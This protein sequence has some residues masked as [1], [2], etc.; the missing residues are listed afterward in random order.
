VKFRVEH[1]GQI[2]SAELDIRPLTLLVGRNNTNKTWA[3][4][5]LYG[6]L[7]QAAWGQDL[8]KL[9]PAE[10]G[11]AQRPEHDA[12]ARVVAP[13]VEQFAA[14]AFSAASPGT[15]TGQPS[16]TVS[17]SEL[18][19]PGVQSFTFHLVDKELAALLALP[20][21]L[22]AR[23][24]ASLRLDVDEAP[25]PGMKII[26]LSSDGVLE[27]GHVRGGKDASRSVEHG[28]RFFF[29]SRPELQRVLE[30][31]LGDLAL[32]SF[33]RVFA[34][35]A[36][37]KALTAIYNHLRD[38]IEQTLPKPAADFVAFLRRA[39]A[40][41]AG[42]PQTPQVNQ[43]QHLLRGIIE[44]SVSYAQ[45][46][47]GWQAVYAP[48]QETFTL[49]IQAASSLVRA[50]AGLDLM[51]DDLGRGDVLLVDEV[52]MNAHPATQ[53]ALVELLC[54]LV[55][56]GVYVIMTSHSP[57]VVDHL[58]NLM[59][60]STLPAEMQERFRERF[61]LRTTDAFLSPDMVSAYLFERGGHVQDIMDREAKRISW[62]TFAE[63]S[64]QL[65]NLYADLDMATAGSDEVDG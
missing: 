59:L 60:A 15:Q 11:V 54:T 50:M 23:S 64:D 1:L 44:G 18:L 16:M 33:R 57:Y 2:A 42:T 51:L 13:R 17:R 53:L 27:L 5:A 7:E 38:A 14:A 48:Q 22:T 35:P 6:L 49:P 34:L 19:S 40:R 20:L 25:A 63:V 9:A 45:A 29:R 58:N 26:I 62:T 43:A 24:S 36:E 46:G 4:Y 8:S 37:R 65:S 3:A 52:E 61:S 32:Q 39:Q 31:A 47:P 10:P 28:S 21:E 55:H 12:V 56:A 41:L 30:R